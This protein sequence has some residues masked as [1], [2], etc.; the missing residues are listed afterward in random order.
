MTQ[1]QLADPAP[2]ADSARNA[3]R[4]PPQ[5]EQR[6][7]DGE[8]V[9]AI[10]GRWQLDNLAALK[11]LPDDETPPL[12]V[13]KI[14]AGDLVALDTA[15]AML[16]L[17]LIGKP[18]SMPEL[19]AMRDSDVELLRLVNQ[20]LH[21]KKSE[22]K[23]RDQ[24]W[25]TMFERTGAAVARAYQQARLLLGFFG[26]VLETGFR[27]M[28]GRRRLRLTAAVHHMEQTGLDAVPIVCLLSFLIGAVVAYLGAIVLA[29]F[30]AS[31]Y[32]VELVNYSFLREFGVL[33][34]AILVAGRSGSAFTA[35]IGAMKSGQEIDAIRT[36]GLDPI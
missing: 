16:L 13:E 18:K 21:Q 11:R 1:A 27:V 30:G 31:I 5:W 20:R 23:R 8:Q 22:P 34:T 2:G 25:L 17:E 32:T 10:A 9:L 33:L 14:H 19:V 26:A 36:L 12:Q 15:G 3:T 4:S 6:E 29:D 28:L 7:A 35:E 24:G